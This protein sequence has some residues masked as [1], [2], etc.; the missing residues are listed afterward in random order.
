MSRILIL[1]LGAI[2]APDA[3][4][5]AVTTQEVVCTGVWRKS[6]CTWTIYNKSTA[7]QHVKIL[8]SGLVT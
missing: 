5:Q 4:E 6:M 7:S 3:V 2:E 8:Y 1:D